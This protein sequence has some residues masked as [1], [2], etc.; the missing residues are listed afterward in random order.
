MVEIEKILDEL[1]AK[2][3]VRDDGDLLSEKKFPRRMSHIESFNAKDQ[4]EADS[5]LWG[6]LRYHSMTDSIDEFE[7]RENK[8]ATDIHNE[9]VS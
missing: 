6:W 5:K 8:G 4:K 1:S 9:W 3:G 7:A 2:D